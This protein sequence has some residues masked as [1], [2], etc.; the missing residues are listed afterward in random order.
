MNITIATG[1]AYAKSCRF[2]NL[3]EQNT[4]MGQKVKT[5]EVNLTKLPNYYYQPVFKGAIFNP[6]N[7]KRPHID[8]GEKLYIGAYGPPREPNA[9]YSV[10]RNKAKAEDYE[11]N[12]NDLSNYSFEKS[13]LM[14]CE[15]KNV[16]M[17][18]TSFENSNL[19]ACKFNGAQTRSVNFEHV[20][21]CD[22]DFKGAKFGRNT[23][24]I[25]ANLMGAD[26]RETDLTYVKL[27]NA[28]YN[29][30]TRFPE[31]MEPED[32]EGM[33]LLTDGADFS[34]PP[35]PLS[36]KDDK[37]EYERKRFE[38][39]KIRNLSIDNVNFNNNS[40]KRADLKGW[41][42]DKCNF[43]NSDLTRVYAREMKATD[44]DFSGAKMKQINL[45]EADLKN[46]NMRNA[47]LRGAILTFNSA[48]NL[49][50]RGARYDQYTVF[51]EDFDP[52]QNGMIY[53]ESTPRVYGA[54]TEKQITDFEY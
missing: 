29:E 48:E 38:F 16:K 36:G 26:L 47:D 24:M 39:A 19:W 14:Y 22:A 45:S 31:N 46:V 3:R 17:E 12:G 34:L 20:N 41:I 32:L 40:L 49:N 7:S 6:I 11:F 33:I 27:E 54:K 18:N 50:V 15:F 21:F 23:S 28:L 43:Q 44:C 25:G 2:Q 37:Y 1:S 10:I 8:Y 9:K 5:N 35:L 4:N 30:T 13:S 51:N 42:A 52:K 53:E